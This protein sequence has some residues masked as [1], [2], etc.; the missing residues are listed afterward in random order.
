MNLLL[1]FTSLSIVVSSCP[2][3]LSSSPPTLSSQNDPLSFANSFLSKKFYPLVGQVQFPRLFL[4]YRWLTLELYVS[5]TLIN[6]QIIVNQTFNDL[7]M[8]AHLPVTVLNALVVCSEDFVRVPVEMDTCLKNLTRYSSALER[9]ES[10]STKERFE[11]NLDRQILI[12]KSTMDFVKQV[13]EKE[14]FD[15][16]ELMEF[17][18]GMTDLIM[19]N[20]YDAAKIHIELMIRALEYWK[21]T[22]LTEESDWNDLKLAISSSHLAHKGNM[23]AQFFARYFEID[24]IE[25]S[26]KVW[27]IEDF[28]ITK[29]RQVVQSEMIDPI[30]GEAFFNDRQRMYTDVMSDGT[31]RA[32]DEIFENKNESIFK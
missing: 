8:M 24:D 10:V 21:T 11:K 17:S 27:L 19:E 3:D 13:L 30:I 23:A 7:K 26:D 4:S 29:V 14:D 1:F 32:L 5:G 31:K 22:V 16:F 2:F 12:F 28:D 9:V 20:A 25:N 18:R 6:R 15:R